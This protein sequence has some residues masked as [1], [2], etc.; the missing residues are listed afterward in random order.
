MNPPPDAPREVRSLPL[1]RFANAETPHS[2]F[3]QVFDARNEPVIL[4]VEVDLDAGLAI[5]IDH[6]IQA[7]GSVT[8]L[9][10]RCPEGMKPKLRVIGGDFVLR[11]R[12]DR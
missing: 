10:E 2:R 9:V 6:I 12:G 1:P 5:Q 3:I 4:V 8:A 11:W 7:D